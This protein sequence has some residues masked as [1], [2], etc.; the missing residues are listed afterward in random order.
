MRR[1]N[2]EESVYWSILAIIGIVLLADRLRDLIILEWDISIYWAAIIGWVLIGMIG[3]LACFIIIR[4]VKLNNV[5]T[6]IIALYRQG[7]SDKLDEFITEL[8]RLKKDDKK[9]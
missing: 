5:I 6:A 7:K 3:F 1:L 9:N 8:N 4:I 2:L